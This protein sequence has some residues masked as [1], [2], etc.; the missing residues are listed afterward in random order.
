MIELID[1]TKTRLGS[2]DADDLRSLLRLLANQPFLKFRVSYGDELH[3]H[4]G[5]ERFC[6]YP[7]GRG[8]VMGTYV[9]TTRASAWSLLSGTHSVLLASD[10]DI[11]NSANAEGTGVNQ[12]DIHIVESKDYIAPGS[13]VQ[14]ANPFVTKYGFGLALKF[15]DS[16]EFF[17]VP[18]APEPEDAEDPI[19]DWEVLMP[20]EHLLK[21][22]PGLTWSYS[23]DSSKTEDAA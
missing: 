7:R 11:V 4:L 14:A 18:S 10:T 15:T 1:L 12:E 16:S 19:A 8:T 9:V 21:V 23:P 2:D 6:K 3:I 5:G 17:L 20:G 13:T 22:G